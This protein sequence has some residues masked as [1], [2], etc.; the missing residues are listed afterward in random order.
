MRCLSFWQPWGW[1]VVSGLKDVDNRPRGTKYRGP[2]LVHAS[3]K[4]DTEGERWLYI[5]ACKGRIP[6]VEYPMRHDQRI[7]YGAIIGLVEVVDCVTQHKSPWFCGPNGLVVRNASQFEK[8]FP[9]KG[10]LG[11]FD[12][13]DTV[14]K[15]ILWK[16]MVECTMVMEQWKKRLSIG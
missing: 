15:Q 11:L 12:V 8:P 7:V 4:W 5:N 9:F 1:L 14:V 3:K 13:P 6:L 10:Q 16:N 2:L